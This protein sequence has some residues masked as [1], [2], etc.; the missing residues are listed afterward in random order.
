M[1]TKK[2]FREWLRSLPPGTEFCI[3]L[4]IDTC[5]IAMFTG[6]QARADEANAPWANEFMNKFDANQSSTLADAIR[7]ADG[8]RSRDCAL[9]STS[10]AEKP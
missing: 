9:T 2:E 1:K 8:L 7:I 3:G 6:Q 4:R 5:P 10:D